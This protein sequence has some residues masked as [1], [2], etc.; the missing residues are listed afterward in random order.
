M[1]VFT[2]FNRDQLEKHVALYSL[3]DLQAFQPIPEG[4]ENSNYFVTTEQALGETDCVLTLFETLGFNEVPFFTKLMQH[5]QSCGLPVAA[6][7]TTLDGMTMTIFQGKPTV[8]FEKLPGSHAMHPGIAHCRAIG[9]VL[10]ELHCAEYGDSL[11]RSYEYDLDWLKESRIRLSGFFGIEDLELLDQVTAEYASLLE[12]NHQHLRRSIIHGDLFR[13]N[14]LFQG[15]TV[16]GLIDF[17]HAG[18]GHSVLDLAITI[19]DWCH[20]PEQQYLPDLHDSL[21]DGYQQVRPL[22]EFERDSLP[23]FLMV[24]ATK[25]WIRR[26]QL[27]FEGTERK[28]PAEFRTILRQWFDR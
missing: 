26:A 18:V 9:R 27:V 19:N 12:D 6:P 25:F 16:T 15:E 28:D 3:G 22:N 17:Y 21:L 4:I 7:I 8:L 10:A 2:T 11:S 14:A 23:V 24:A 13:D 1:A 20:G 5:L